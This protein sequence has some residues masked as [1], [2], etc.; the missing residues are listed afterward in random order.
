M[1]QFSRTAT[2]VKKKIKLFLVSVMNRAF[3]LEA[4]IFL[5]VYTHHI[6]TIK[7]DK[8]R[9]KWTAKRKI[10]LC[11][12]EFI[13]VFLPV[14]VYECIDSQTIRPAIGEIKN[15]DLWIVLS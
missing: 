11:T 10:A 13:I 2:A 5:T 3:M 15:I 12:N 9:Q 8:M 4:L 14:T 6:H 7:R 1:N